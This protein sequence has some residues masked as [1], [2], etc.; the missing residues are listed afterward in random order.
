MLDHLDT[1]WVLGA[2]ITGVV[3]ARKRYL[4]WAARNAALLADARRSA[5]E[6]STAAASAP[7]PAAEPQRP[8]P[9]PARAQPA[10]RP[11]PAMMPIDPI[12]VW[13]DEP[14]LAA[15]LRRPAT[16]VI[17]AEILAPPLALR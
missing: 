7:A 8:L 3:W 4:E 13:A 2:I 9:A 10:P 6:L 15:A 16:A 5:V 1:Y 17:L 12:A 11:M 14:A